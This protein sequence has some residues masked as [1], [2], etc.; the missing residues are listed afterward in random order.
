MARNIRS[1]LFRLA[2][3]LAG[4]GPRKLEWEPGS[5]IDGTQATVLQLMDSLPRPPFKTGLTPRL[6]VTSAPV[7]LKPSHFGP[8]AGEVNQTSAK[9]HRRTLTCSH[10]EGDVLAAISFHLDADARAPLLVTAIAVIEGPAPASERSLG[11]AAAAILLHYLQMAAVEY[12]RPHRI[13]YA[14]PPGNRAIA[15]LLGFLPTHAPSAYAQA[16]S[17]YMEWSAPR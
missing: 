16:G 3:Y 6:K 5:R 12:G 14:P 2:R 13:G 10:S 4:R 17:R 7:R 1:D 9:G 11:L 8:A 15:T